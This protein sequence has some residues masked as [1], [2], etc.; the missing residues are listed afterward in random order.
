MLRVLPEIVGLV[1]VVWAL[2]DAITSDESQV[3]H[4]PK[5]L[6]VILIL[7]FPIVG[8]LVWLVAGKNRVPSHGRGPRDWST[9]QAQYGTGSR[10]PD[11]DPHFL[12]R[13]RLQKWEQELKARE[14]KA[15]EDGEQGPS[16][17]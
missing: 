13:L 8:A 11:D 3:Q 6:W 10:A 15:R 5:V 17:G 16:V 2:V 4:L 1:L 7:L 14:Q 12:E 9:G